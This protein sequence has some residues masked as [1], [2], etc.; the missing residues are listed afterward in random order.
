MAKHIY[1]FEDIPEGDPSRPPLAALRAMRLIGM[2]LSRTGWQAMSV[3]RRRAI[4]SAG[5]AENVETDE[6]RRLFDGAPIREMK[7][8]PVIPDPP[9]DRIPDSVARAFGPARVIS[10]EFWVG[11]TN[12]DRHV[13]Y[14]LTGNTRLLFR[15]LNEMALRARGKLPLPSF[16]WTGTL[17]RGEL[18]TTPEMLKLL[19][20]PHFLDGRACIL[21][22]VAGIR[23]ARWASEILDLHAATPTGPVEVG[24]S[25]DTELRPGTVL[26]QAH[27]STLE[28]QF[29]PSASVL[30]VTTSAAALYDIVQ[31]AGE[32]ATIENVR[33]S[34]EPWAPSDADDEV[35][36][37]A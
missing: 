16:G 26:W 5:A 36:I 28:G 31:R 19:R 12:L 35:T 18:R 4:I 32:R 30:A 2:A 10:Q 24:F 33:L 9:A 27:V 25:V 15:A 29:S 14:M 1:A 22:R 21:A 23:A 34:D 37:G 20:M 13:L 3:D 7:L 6:L 11:V 8:V 17:A